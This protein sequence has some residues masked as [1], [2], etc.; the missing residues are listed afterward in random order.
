MPMKLLLLVTAVLEAGV[1]VGLGTRCVV[2]LL[3]N[4]WKRTT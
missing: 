1:G 4:P 3:K 2:C